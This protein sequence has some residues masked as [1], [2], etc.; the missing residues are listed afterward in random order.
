MKWKGL[1]VR[2]LV[3]EQLTGR[4]PHVTTQ[5]VTAAR[6]FTHLMS[7]ASQESPVWQQYRSVLIRHN[8]YCHRLTFLLLIFPCSFRL[9]LLSLWNHRDLGEMTLKVYVC[10]FV[11][12]HSAVIHYNSLQMI[13]DRPFCN[14]WPRRYHI[15][16]GD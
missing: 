5:V 11:Q 15:W 9:V 3:N 13:L 6:L 2:I 8:R 1:T 14:L 4:I 16:S 10:I 7:C 12:S